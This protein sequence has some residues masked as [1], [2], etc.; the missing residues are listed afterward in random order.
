M[1]TRTTASAPRLRWRKS[2]R[3]A[4]IQNEYR[5]ILHGAGWAD[6]PARGHLRLDGADV[7]SFLQALV[8]NDVSRL[9]ANDGLYATYLTPNGR[10][11]TDLEIYR[12]P[13]FW[14][15]GLESERAAL[16]ADRLDQSVFSEDVRITNVTNELAEI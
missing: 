12:R 9:E 10:M 11:L 4:V 3:V 15:V 14:H 5:I 2:A 7:G 6:R 13:G 16:I 1:V 8:S